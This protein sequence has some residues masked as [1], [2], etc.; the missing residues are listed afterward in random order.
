MCRHGSKRE[1]T[2]FLEIGEV[3]YYYV[4]VVILMNGRREARQNQL[5]G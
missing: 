5:P 1:S 4:Y 2:Q 3:A